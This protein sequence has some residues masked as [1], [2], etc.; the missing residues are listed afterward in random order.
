[1]KEFFK[2]LGPI[3]QIL[4]VVLLGIYYFTAPAENTL[5][6]AGGLLVIAGIIAHIL[7]NKKNL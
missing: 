1:M 6:S 3:V 7:I 4:G 2:Y 5:L